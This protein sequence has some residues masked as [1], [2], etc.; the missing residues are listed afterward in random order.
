MKRSILALMIMILGIALITGCP[1]SDNQIKCNEG[2]GPD[3]APKATARQHDEIPVQ[4]PADPAALGA[5]MAS[6]KAAADGVIEETAAERERGGD[7]EELFRKG[8][9]KIHEAMRPEFG[10]AN[11]WL[12]NERDGKIGDLCGRLDLDPERCYEI[13]QEELY[14]DK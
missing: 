8:F 10:P 14:G 3:E 11:A 9:K 5:L 12:F 6:M 13:E 4:M 7:P 2:P 1:K